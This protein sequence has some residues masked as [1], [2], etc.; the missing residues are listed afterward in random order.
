MAPATCRAWCCG[1]GRHRPLLLGSVV[2]GDNAAISVDLT[3]PDIVRDGLLLIPRGTLHLSRLMVLSQGV[4]HDRIKVRN[5]G[6]APIV[7]S[8][9]IEFDADFVDLFEVRGTH[10]LQ[11]G[12]RHPGAVNGRDV[13]LIYTGLDSVQRATR[14]GFESETIALSERHAHSSSSCRRT[15]SSKSASASA[16]RTARPGRPWRFRTRCRPWRTRWSAAARTGAT[17]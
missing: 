5:Y 17:S 1:S 16:A 13:S 7:V 14:V 2:R 15:G 11:R 10:R 9:D 8:I 6:L 4:L 12:Q 3:N